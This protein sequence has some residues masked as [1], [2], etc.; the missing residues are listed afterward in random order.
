MRSDKKLQAMALEIRSFCAENGDEKVVSRYS[1][2]FTEGYDAYGVTKE[3]MEEYTKRFC[4]AHKEEL[5]LDGFLKLGDILLESGKYEE[6]SFAMSFLIPLEEQFSAKTFRNLGEWLEGGVRNWA[7]ADF[8][9]GEVL[10][11]FLERGIVALED[12]SSWRASGSKWRR[13]AVPVSMLTL[14]KTDSDYG[15]LL[16]FIEPLMMDDE[17]F[18]QQGLGW[19]LREAWKQ[20]PKPVEAFLLKWKESAPRKIY[21]YATERMTPENRARFRRER[22]NEDRGHDGHIQ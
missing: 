14:L 20:R 1:R 13:R 11:R 19:F 21:Q 9:C 3:A 12:F 7:H 5:D 2:F 10:S 17:K 16:D 6:V 8:L 18:V 4:E 22:K 15:K